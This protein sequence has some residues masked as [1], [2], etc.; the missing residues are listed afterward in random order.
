MIKKFVE[1]Y[2]K[3]ITMEYSKFKV[4]IAGN[5]LA[6]KALPNM[7]SNGILIGNSALVVD[8]IADSVAL[9]PQID[10]IFKNFPTFR[11]YVDNITT[12]VRQNP[13]WAD[14]VN[15]ACH[16]FNICYML[17]IYMDLTYICITRPSTDVVRDSGSSLQYNIKHNPRACVYVYAKS[18]SSGN[19]NK[20]VSNKY[21]SIMDDFLK[22][23]LSGQLDIEFEAE[24]LRLTQYN[25]IKLTKLD[26]L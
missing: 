25:C 3:F 19:V 8:S 12:Q 18:L 26:L 21:L 15:L 17:N 4:A 7:R 5:T 11:T 1:R 23:S 6:K 13:N 10:R 16:V 9:P 14:D 22:L 20:S 24:D 2:E